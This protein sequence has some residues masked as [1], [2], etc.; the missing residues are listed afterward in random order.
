MGKGP[1]EVG[2]KTTSNTA[3]RSERVGT[4]EKTTVFGKNK[5]FVTLPREVAIKL[6][7][8]KSAV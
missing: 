6:C 2:N 4:K 8:R 5:F 1:H 3:R 7:G